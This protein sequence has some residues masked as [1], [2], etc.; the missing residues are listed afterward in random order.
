MWH[1]QTRDLRSWNP[2]FRGYTSTL[3]KAVE[4]LMQTTCNIRCVCFQSFLVS[5]V[6][7]Q[8][9]MIPQP[10]TISKH[11]SHNHTRWTNTRP[12][13]TQEGQTSVPQPHKLSKPTLSPTRLTFCVSA[14]LAHVH[15]RRMHHVTSLWPPDWLGSDLSA[16]SRY[17]TGKPSIFGFPSRTPFTGGSLWHDSQ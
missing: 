14:M 8:D 3:K 10:H 12:A 5:E 2:I 16:V 15:T 4:V 11:Q 17:P 9:D 6:Y 1:D 7:S 13:P